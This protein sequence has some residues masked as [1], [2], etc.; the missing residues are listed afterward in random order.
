[1]KNLITEIVLLSGFVL[2]VLSCTSQQEK[3]FQN[4]ENYF[5]N[6]HGYKVTGDINKVI[7][8]GEGSNCSVC[9]KVFAQTARE[10]LADSS[11]FLITAKGSI[12]DVQPFIN[13]KQNCFFDWQLN[14]SEL[15]NSR[16]IYFN[17]NKVDTIIV[18]NSEELM[19]QMDSFKNNKTG[20]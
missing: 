2:S 13:S 1:M 8:I 15:S 14:S 19:Q 6:K 20:K 12:V 5:E 16:V 17:N 4:I 10:Y 9:D 11:V 7:I 18:I 3:E